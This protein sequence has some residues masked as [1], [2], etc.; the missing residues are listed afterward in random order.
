MLKTIRVS[1]T[2]DQKG[3]MSLDTFRK[4]MSKAVPMVP[5]TYAHALKRCDQDSAAAMHPI[6]AMAENQTPGD[7]DNG[8]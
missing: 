3:L 2:I 1:G 8:E 4:R 6:H 5:Q 7:R